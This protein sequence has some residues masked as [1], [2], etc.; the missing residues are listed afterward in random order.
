MKPWSWGPLSYC[1]ATL[2]QPLLGSWNCWCQLAPNHSLLMLVA[3]ELSLQNVMDYLLTTLLSH[4]LQFSTSLILSFVHL[5]LSH[6]CEPSHRPAAFTF[7]NEET[8]TISSAV[9]YPL[10]QW[11]Y[12]FSWPRETL[13]IQAQQKSTAC[14]REQKIM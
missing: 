13:A 5:L 11:H 3:S 7:S 9:L 14:V 6:G 1:P 4:N 2:I 12:L 8:A 10:D